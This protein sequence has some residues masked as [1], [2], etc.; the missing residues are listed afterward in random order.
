[1]KTTTK[2]L[3]ALDKQLCADVQ[4][5]A[6]EKHDGNFTN[7][8]RVALKYFLFAREKHLTRTERD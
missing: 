7:A 1:M 6:N 8:V 5:Y 4:A 2:K 3:I